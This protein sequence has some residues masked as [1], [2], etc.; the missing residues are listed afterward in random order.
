MPKA[1]LSQFDL[2]PTQQ[3]IFSVLQDGCL[4]NRDEILGCLRKEY[5]TDE[6][7]KKLYVTI[8]NHIKLIRKKIGPK[9][10]QIDCVLKERGI[11]YRMSRNLANSGREASRG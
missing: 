10:L 6:E 11:H 5:Q 3:S 9:G 2:T 8:Q 4:H 7:G 1:L